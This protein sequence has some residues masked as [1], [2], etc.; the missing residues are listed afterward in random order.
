[1]AALIGACNMADA[2]TLTINNTTNCTYNLSIGG[3]GGGGGVTVAVPGSSSFNSAPPSPGIF[4]VKIM[5][6]DVTGGLS[7]IDVSNGSPYANS[8][9]LPAPVCSSAV[10][11]LTAV[12]QILPNGDVVLTLL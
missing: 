10:G 7:Q 5:Y 8:L 6:A 2:N 4:G 12:W 3:I 9:A 1:M 11:Y